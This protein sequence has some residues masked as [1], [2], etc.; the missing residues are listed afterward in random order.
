MTDKIKERLYK[1]SHYKH[2]DDI[3]IVFLG[4]L[5]LYLIVFIN[6]NKYNNTIY[7]YTFCT[8]YWVYNFIKSFKKYDL[9]TIKRNKLW[10]ITLSSAESITSILLIIITVIVCNYPLD[11]GYIW[12]SIIGIILLIAVLIISYKISQYFKKKIIE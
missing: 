5:L 4:I 11:M 10:I 9:S 7:L 3:Y 12:G 1:I 8:G 6:L 2:F